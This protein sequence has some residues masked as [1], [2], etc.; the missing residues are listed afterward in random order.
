M[1]HIWFCFCL[2]HTFINIYVLQLG[3]MCRLLIVLM[4]VPK[5]GE[6]GVGVHKRGGE[7]GV[8]LLPPTEAKILKKYIG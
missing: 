4:G 3:L 6:P 2:D 5:V 1:V 7:P 8:A